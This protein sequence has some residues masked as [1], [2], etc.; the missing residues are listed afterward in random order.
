MKNISL[1]LLVCLYLGAGF[2]HFWHPQ[3]YIAI[4]PPYI[5]NP[6]LVNIAAGIAEIALGLMAIF[7]ATRKIACF[8]IIAMLFAFI[9]AHVYTIQNAGCT[10]NEICLK[11]AIMWARLFIIQPFLIAWPV[12]IRRQMVK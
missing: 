1:V 3:F 10:E 5:S 11:Q 8:G 7:P 12:Y 6:K 4:I 9:P 2:N